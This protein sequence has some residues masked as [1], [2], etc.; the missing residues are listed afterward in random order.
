[1]ELVYSNMSCLIYWI[2]GTE[3]FDG[4]EFA[5]DGATQDMCLALTAGCSEGVPFSPIWQKS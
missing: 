4:E 5:I 1:M 3:L 2:Y